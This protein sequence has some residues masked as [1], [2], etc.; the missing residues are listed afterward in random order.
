MGYFLV[1]DVDRPSVFEMN[2]SSC[3][4]N[5]FFLRYFTVKNSR[6]LIKYRDFRISVTF[7]LYLCLISTDI[8]YSCHN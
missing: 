3:A 7:M 5:A 4:L 6:W 2:A 8:F 1:A